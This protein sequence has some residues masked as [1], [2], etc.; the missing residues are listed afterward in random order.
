MGMLEHT[1]AQ[2]RSLRLS[3]IA[4]ELTQLLADAEEGEMSYLSFA[5]RLAEHELSRRQSSR[6]QR[7]HKAA[8]A[9]PVVA[10]AT[11]SAP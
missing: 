7:N 1:A 9:G 6:V 5:N 3:A 10:T 4:S 2:Y 11:G 8:G